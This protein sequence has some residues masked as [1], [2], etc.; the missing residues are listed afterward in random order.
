MLPYCQFKTLGGF[1][2]TYDNTV[3]WW[4]YNR[5]TEFFR[6]DMTPGRYSKTH[7]L[8][9]Y[10]FKEDHWTEKTICGLTV[11]EDA[12]VEHEDAGD[13]GDGNCKRCARFGRIT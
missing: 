1:K 9:D 2:M 5:A 6:D 13:M 11:P 7:I 10:V 12:I 8:A 3:S 4:R